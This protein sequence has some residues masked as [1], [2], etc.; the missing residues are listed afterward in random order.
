VL[1][2]CNE[3]AGPKMKIRKASEYLQY[4]QRQRGREKR[5]KSA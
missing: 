4:L 1:I 5:G 3:A 2:V